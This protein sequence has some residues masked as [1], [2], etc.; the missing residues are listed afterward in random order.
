M[1]PYTIN[2][3][4]AVDDVTTG[5]GTITVGSAAP[6]VTITDYNVV[7]GEN[8]ALNVLYE[9]TDEVEISVIDATGTAVAFTAADGK[10]T[11]A[12][13]PAKNVDMTYTVTVGDKSTTISIKGYCDYIAGTSENANLVALAGSINTYGQAAKNYFDV[14]NADHAALTV[15]SYTASN[16]TKAL[17]NTGAV[18]FKGAS[19]VFGDEVELLFRMENYNREQMFVNDEL[20]PESEINNHLSSDGTYVYFSFT[21]KPAQFSTSYTVRAGSIK[22]GDLIPEDSED[23]DHTLSPEENVYRGSSTITY[24]VDA[25]IDVMQATYAGQTSAKALAT[26]NLVNALG[27]YGAAATTYAAN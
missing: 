20:I 1:A 4:T 18:T 10:V 12:D 19:V 16:T 6:E 9:A 25:Y 14:D 2:G 3:N 8:F 15:D 11:I 23:Y 24:S 5:V 26:L 27:H 21:V 13:I 17:S 22:A 7:L